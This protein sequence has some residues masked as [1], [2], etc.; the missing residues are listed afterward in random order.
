MLMTTDTALVQLAVFGDRDAF[1]SIYEESFRCVYAFAARRTADRAAAEALTE[2]ILVRVFQK[3][4]SYSGEVP[5][6]AWLQSVAKSVVP[7]SGPRRRPSR[8]SPKAPVAHS[9]PR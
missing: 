4:E 1:A 2:V 7:P 3:L 8:V 5:F 6:A 9:F